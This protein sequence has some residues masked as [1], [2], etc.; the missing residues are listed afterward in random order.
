MTRTSHGLGFV[1]L[2]LLVVA[3][4]IGLWWH[5]ANQADRD[6]FQQRLSGAPVLG[7][8]VPAP[9]PTLAPLT[10]RQGDEDSGIQFPLK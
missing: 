8:F 9:G 4:G 3:A 7:Y 1:L 2:V 5:S 10:P 6:R